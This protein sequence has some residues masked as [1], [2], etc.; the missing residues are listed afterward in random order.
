MVDSIADRWGSHSPHPNLTVVW[1]ER[2]VTV[3]DS[4]S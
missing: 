1:F 4:R 3:P 2:T